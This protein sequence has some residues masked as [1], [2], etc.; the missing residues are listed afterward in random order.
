MEKDESMILRDL[1]V[2]TRNYTIIDN[3]TGKP[4]DASNYSLTID[5]E[6]ITKLNKLK[7]MNEE[8]I[9]QAALKSQYTDSTTVDTFTPEDNS[10]FTPVY[11]G[12]YINDQDFNDNF[13]DE[14]MT[15][16]TQVQEEKNE[17]AEEPNLIIQDTILERVVARDPNS[18]QE[19]SPIVENTENEPESIA[20][21]NQD[22]LKEESNNTPQENITLQ[23]A[24]EQIINIETERLGKGIKPPKHSKNEEDKIKLDKD[25]VSE[26]RGIAWLGYLLFFIPLLINKNNRFVRIHANEGL[27]LN[28][29]EILGACLMLPLLLIN[30]LTGTTQLIVT[31]LALMGGII[32]A[33]CIITIIP[34]MISSIVGHYNQNPW[35]WKK[36]IIKVHTNR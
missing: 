9:R 25:E 20:S 23:Q 6:V 4:I 35:L 18:V 28:I 17:P 22:E 11:S 3:V 30:N 31:I 16:D 7:A 36:R 8:K 2:D 19:Q 26:G 24:S 33:T 15:D 10:V 5:T 27:E 29:M 21:E 13:V 14:L 1:P 34:M 12:E 32:L